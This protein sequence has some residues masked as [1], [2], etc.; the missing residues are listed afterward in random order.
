MDSYEI[1]KEKL[2]LR[3]IQ[4]ALL[5]GYI[6]KVHTYVI[7]VMWLMFAVLDSGGYA[8]KLSILLQ[9]LI[10]QESLQKR[11]PFANQIRPPP[12]IALGEIIIV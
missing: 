8:T 5:K 2:G 7:D 11:P 9:K 4:G 1:I 3:P 6:M 10:E 12:L